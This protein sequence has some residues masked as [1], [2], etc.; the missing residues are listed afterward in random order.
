MRARVEN[1]STLSALKYHFVVVEKMV[2]HFR[3]LFPADPNEQPPPVML[4]TRLA[5][6]PYD[7]VPRFIE[8]PP[9]ADYTPISKLRKSRSLSME[10]ARGSLRKLSSPD[11]LRKH[12]PPPP[13]LTEPPPLPPPR[14]PRPC[15]LPPAPPHRATSAD[16]SAAVPTCLS[17]PQLHRLV[18]RP[19]PSPSPSSQP[20]LPPA[21]PARL[22]PQLQAP[23][24]QLLPPHAPRLPTH[25][26]PHA[27]VLSTAAPRGSPHS[28]HSPPGSPLTA[29]DSPPQTRFPV[30]PPL[31][32]KCTSRTATEVRALVSV[33]SATATPSPTSPTSVRR[34]PPRP[35]RFEVVSSQSTQ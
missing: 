30:A 1:L 22:S 34:P 3:E 10:L 29:P 33:A 16:P 5:H 21:K 11:P 7:R 28:A 23:P 14:S 4:S 24:S 25:P 19:S 9:V 6:F 12:Q 31:S 15:L 35:P 32:A 13:P 18:H 20:P 26:P 27:L 8:P 17:S 2:T